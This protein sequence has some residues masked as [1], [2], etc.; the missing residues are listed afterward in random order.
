MAN[1]RYHGESR[2]KVVVKPAGL[3]PLRL[4]TASKCSH[5]SFVKIGYLLNFPKLVFSSVKWVVSVLVLKA[6]GGQMRSYS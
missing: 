2:E 6:V 5:L 4:G 1:A 3:K